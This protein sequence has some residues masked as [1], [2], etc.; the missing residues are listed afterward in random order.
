MSSSNWLNESYDNLGRSSDRPDF[1]KLEGSR[2]KKTSRVVRFLREIPLVVDRHVVPAYG[3]RIPV[4]CTGEEDCP[5]CKE[6]IPVRK[7]RGFYEVVNSETGT[8]E[9]LERGRKDLRKLKMLRSEGKLTE[10]PVVITRTGMKLESEYAFDFVEGTKPKQISEEKKAELIGGFVLEEYLTPLSKKEFYDLIN[11]TGRKGRKDE[12]EDAEEATG[13]A[14]DDMERNALKIYIKKN[15][16]NVT[17]YKSDS[18]DD[19]REKIR[20][21]E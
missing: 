2:N 7:V 19:I 4:T 13:D 14:F 6:N 9:I 3:T 8:V 10:R 11:E 20:N 1:F 21:A 16:L 17:V 5:G 15:S 18:D 12:K